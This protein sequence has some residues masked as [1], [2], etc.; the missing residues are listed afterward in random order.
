MNIKEIS[1]KTIGIIGYG[2]FGKVICQYLFPSNKIILYSQKNNNFTENIKRTE[3]LKDLTASSDLIVPAVP[4]RSFEEVILQLVPFLKDN[5]IIMDV[6]SVKEY[7]V[8]VMKKA[9][10]VFVNIIATHPM[11]GPISI[12]KNNNS[13]KNLN[14]VIYNV[15]CNKEIYMLVKKHLKT[16]ELKLIEIDPILH[17][18]LSANSHFFSKIIKHLASSLELHETL[19]DTPTSAG[20]FRALN[21]TS[22]DKSIIEDMIT[23][24][25]YCKKLLEKIDK[26]L[27]KLEQNNKN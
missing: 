27:R 24:N 13:L 4:I 22:D 15:R 6:C 25:H 7:S 2:S 12:E 8:N 9:L 21:N 17:D 5:Q 10:P 19:F 20:I 3:S 16:L 18:K 11:F 23:Y 26:T 1:K 14:F